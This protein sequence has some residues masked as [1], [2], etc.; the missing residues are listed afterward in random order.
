MFKLGETNFIIERTS[1]IC[2]L[3]TARKSN[4]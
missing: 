3:Q 4:T 2:C 1:N